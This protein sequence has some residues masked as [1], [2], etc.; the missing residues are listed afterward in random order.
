MWEFLEYG[1]INSN[2]QAW[3]GISAAER[4]FSIMDSAIEIY[5]QWMH[6]VLPKR[7]NRVG[8]RKWIR[9]F[10]SRL[11]GENNNEGTEI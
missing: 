5:R 6:I 4:L 8:N 2:L 11:A 9:L 1:G 3:L 10:N 7:G